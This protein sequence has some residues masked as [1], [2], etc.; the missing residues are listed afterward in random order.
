MHK[1]VCFLGPPFREAHLGK[2]RG[3]DRRPRGRLRVRR[4]SRL[5]LGVGGDDSNGLVALFGG[6][7]GGAGA[8]LCCGMPWC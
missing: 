1:V 2:R 4:Q 6:I 3:R 7:G 5:R 8:A